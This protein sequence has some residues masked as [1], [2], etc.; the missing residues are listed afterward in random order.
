MSTPLVNHYYYDTQTKA[1]LV[2]SLTQ[3]IKELEGEPVFLCIG[4]ERHILD[5][6]GPLTG[7]MLAEKSLDILVYGTLEKPLHAK[8]LVKEI[9]TIKSNHPHIIEIAIDAAIGIEKDIGII[10][11][12]KGPLFPGKALGKR[13]PAVGQL[14]ITGIVG[15]RDL[16]KGKQIIN[17]SL[18]HVYHMAQLISSAIHEW[19]L[20]HKK[21]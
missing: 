11:F 3:T 2:E 1:L 7:T 16:D 18:H 14:S 6:L 10:K 12:K 19:Y 9:E 17:G 4:S 13:L 20:Y 21:L 8:N 15:K 5:C